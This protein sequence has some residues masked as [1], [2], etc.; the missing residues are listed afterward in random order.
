MRILTF[1]FLLMLILFG[2]TFASL[3]S[4]PVTVSYYI[5]QKDLPL[6]LL[7]IFA[8]GIGGLIG[9]AI[10]GLFILNAKLKIYHLKQKLKVAEKEI[11]NLRAI[12][13]LDK[14]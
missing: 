10:S 4:D 11:E 3:N 12:P 5:G 6:S 8:F 1:L 14:H 9:M 7:L 13:L 2:I